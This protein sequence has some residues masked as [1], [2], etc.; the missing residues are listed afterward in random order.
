MKRTTYLY[1]LL[2]IAF[3]SGSALAVMP[4]NDKILGIGYNAGWSTYYGGSEEDV[5]TDMIVVGEFVYFTG[6]TK[7]PTS[8]SS[9]TSN[10]KALAGGYDAFLVKFDQSGKKIW[11]TYIGGTGDD[12][13]TGISFDFELQT[14]VVAGYTSSKTEIASNDGFRNQFGGGNYDAFV[15]VY[16]IS[17]KRKWSSYYGGTGDD[18]V[19]DVKAIDRKILIAGKTSSPSQVA[20]GEIKHQSVLSGN[21]DGMIVL[22]DMKKNIVGWGTYF[23]GNGD[24]EINSVDFKGGII[25]FAGTTNSNNGI[26]YNQ[27]TAYNNGG[28]D[29]FVGRFGDNGEVIWSRYFGGSGSDKALVLHSDGIV[30]AIGGET[31]SQSGIAFNNPYQANPGGAKDGFFAQFRPNGELL[32]SSYFGGTGEDKINT[33]FVAGT[34]L[35]I[36]GKTTSPDGIA[37]LDAPKYE[38]KGGVDAFIGVIDNFTLRDWCSYFGETGDDEALAV[39]FSNEAMYLA[40]HTSSSD[41]KVTPN[42]YQQLYGGSKDGYVTK[43]VRQENT[44]ILNLKLNR[45]EFCTD[46][47]YIV[48]YLAEGFVNPMNVFIIELSDKNGSFLK[49]IEIGRKEARISSSILVRIPENTEF[50][51]R[52]RMRI[53]ALETNFIGSDNGS[54]FTIYPK[55]KPTIQGDNE[56]CQ[57]ADAEYTAPQNNDWYYD[58]SISGGLIVDGQGT[59]KIKV[60]WQKAGAG[61]ISLVVTSSGCN[62]SVR[63]P[64]Q[65]NEKPEVSFALPETICKNA[66]PIKLDGGVPVGGIY[67]IGGKVIT[68]FDPSL[69]PVGI[70]N[71][72]YTFTNQTG[73]RNY[74]EKSIRVLEVPEKPVIKV[75]MDRLESSA[76]NGNVWYLNGELLTNEKSKVIYPKADGIYKVKV[77]AVNGC[78]S[79]FS[80]EIKFTVIR[81]AGIEFSKGELEFPTIFCDESNSISLSIRNFGD[82][83]LVLSSYKIEGTN[84]SD[85]KF[86]GFGKKEIQPKETIYTKVYFAPQ[87]QGSKSATLFIYSNAKNA[88]IA[89]IPLKGKMEKV[90]FELSQNIL[91]FSDLDPNR[92]YEKTINIINNSS[93]YIKF[94]SNSSDLINFE[95]VSVEPLETPPGETSKATI[96]FK[97]GDAGKAYTETLKIS[98]NKC[99]RIAEL[100]LYAKVKESIPQKFDIK[101]GSIN[102]KSG[103]YI[104]IPIQLDD[105]KLL[106]SKGISRISGNLNFNSTLLEPV[107][108]T[109]KGT[110]SLDGKTRIIPIEFNINGETSTQLLLNFRV[111]LGNDTMTTIRFDEIRSNL[112]NVDFTSTGGLIKL[113]DVCNANGPRLVYFGDAKIE[114]KVMTDISNDH[115]SVSFNLL[116]TGETRITIYNSSG[117]ISKTVLNENIRKGFYEKEVSVADLGTG[118]YFIVLETPTA[119]IAKRIA[120]IK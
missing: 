84:S 18:Y 95:L 119:Y 77:L 27:N 71:I 36:A 113:T 80:E 107:E 55:P 33:I 78:E 110:Q 45:E 90:S 8:I 13:A 106:I 108:N 35:F 111:S 74:I 115:L 43:F 31:S 116:E 51:I 94:N 53:R 49:P 4:G 109:P 83:T 52:Y 14:V 93:I 25:Y 91:E 2:L 82:S 112:N 57:G 30:I 59:N 105:P 39:D 70:Y 73:C 50:G 26:N 11:G 100:K 44:R 117:D 48:N 46:S 10:Q 15:S 17:G 40:G 103:D 99:G 85:F 61:H 76:D 28:G 118:L 34:R 96:R 41:F 67:T 19:Y 72:R 29:A 16:D 21:S 88:P 12:Y 47:A 102:A 65:V 87:A 5:V 120:I 20:E 9:P 54:D 37:T 75:Y 32:N 42:A 62:G 101:I 56:I 97:G 114:L 89:K 79:E 23:G 7:S 58:W 63:F 98:D 104:E 66:A 69:Y 81:G 24:D 68:E 22:F 64:V 92:A 3:L 6:Y 60:L 1:I 38:Y 86:D